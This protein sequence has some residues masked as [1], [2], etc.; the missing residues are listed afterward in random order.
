MKLPTLIIILAA[1]ATGSGDP[2]AASTDAGVD[3]IVLVTGATG[4]QGGAVARD[5]LARVY[6]VRGLT[7]NPESERAR[8]MS[9]IGVDMVRGDF[10]DS[11]SLA[12][13]M[14]GVHGVFAVTN[15]WEHGYD[16]EV[17]HGK[18]LVDAAIAAGVQHFVFTSVASADANTGIPHFE[19]KGEIEAYLRDSGINYSI[20]RPVEFMDNLRFYREGILA[21]TY[22]DPRDSAKSHQWIAASDIG[23]FVGEAFDNPE[24]WLG[25]TVEIAGDQLTIA[26]YVQ[27]L[28]NATDVEVRH[29]KMTWTDYEERAGHEMT[30]MLRW[31]DEVGYDVDIDSL[32]SR[33]PDLLTYEQFLAKHDWD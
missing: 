33:Y 15:T 18:Q 16:G 27:A 24:E 14:K 19:S 28:S 12:A 30:V 2:G 6:S 3:K 23:F 7:R 31:F 26:E 29:E 20:V 9:E 4:T 10:D 17:R 32:R 1:L 21:G 8:S 13:A 11:E 5:L 22:F 25:E